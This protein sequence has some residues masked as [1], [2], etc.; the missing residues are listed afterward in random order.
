MSEKKHDWSFICGVSGFLIMIAGTILAMIQLSYELTR[1]ALA[2]VILGVI[3]IAVGVIINKYNQHM[4]RNKVKQ[5]V[6]AVSNWFAEKYREYD[7]I[8]DNVV[9]MSIR[10]HN[11]DFAYRHYCWVEDEDIYFFP[12]EQDFIFFHG[13]SVKA[14]EEKAEI[15]NI[16]VID[17]RSFR[18][19]GNLSYSAKITN[20]GMNVKGAVIGGVLAGD[21]GMIIG[22][23]PQIQSKTETH[24]DRIVELKY[25]EDGALQT[26]TFKYDA[27][28]VFRSLFPEKEQM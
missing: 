6:M 15:I 10:L 12:E 16:H 8:K 18:C 17:I 20:T 26:L 25:Y 2:T 13:A 21:A 9:S 28:E 1:I 14:C 19:S 4:A 22:S 5:D 24:D 27:L 23:R 7:V 3:M 11:V